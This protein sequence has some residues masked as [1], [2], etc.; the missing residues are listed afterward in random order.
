MKQ[1]CSNYSVQ[2]KLE[3]HCYENTKELSIHWIILLLLHNRTSNGRI[4]VWGV[5]VNVTYFQ[6]IYCCWWLMGHSVILHSRITQAGSSNM[7]RWRTVTLLNSSK[8]S[9]YTCVQVLTQ[10]Y[11]YWFHKWIIYKLKNLPYD[12]INISHNQMS[13]TSVIRNKISK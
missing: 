11:V 9:Q 12:T 1:G 13:I 3:P 4:K 2:F 5:L 8:N 6:R 10:T 7:I